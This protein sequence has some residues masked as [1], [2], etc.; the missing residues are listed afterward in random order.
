MIEAARRALSQASS[1]VTFSG[2]G[3]SAESGI[4][5][6]RDA[7]SGA[8]WSKYD[9][10]ELAS[11]QG[12]ARDPAMVSDWYA[13][14]RK[15]IA[16]AEPNPAHLALAARADMTHVTQNVDDLMERAGCRDAIHL[17][18]T[19]ASD[20]CHDR[21]GHREPVNMAE[22]P[23]LR[24]C[25][26][27]GAPLRPDVVWFGEP[28]PQDA[29]SAAERACATCDVLLVV[30]TSAVVYPAAGLIELAKSSGARIV[31]V[32]IQPSEASGV[33]DVEVLGKAGDVVPRIVST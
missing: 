16:G 11:Q 5:T 13:W 28:L 18:G 24:D 20:R 23:P 29:W 15:A 33:A 8:L 2:A 14:R 22:P 31:L 6:F 7:P 17:H 9:P 32:N 21:C 30:G 10:T 12:Y 26:T 27:C 19:I 25:P 1:I 4:P 3:L